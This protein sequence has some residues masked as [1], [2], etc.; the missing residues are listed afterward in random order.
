VFHPGSPRK[1]PDGYSI[2][3]NCRGVA[4]VLRHPFDRTNDR[5][6]AHHIA[7]DVLELAQGERGKVGA[8]VLGGDFLTRNFVEIR[9]H[10]GRSDGVALTAIVEI[11]KEFIPREI[12][13]R[14]D[15]ARKP[16][17]IDVSFGC[18]LFR[19]NSDGCGSPLFARVGRARS[20]GQSFRWSWHIRYCQRERG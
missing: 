1:S 18:R 7:V 5:A 4:K 10:V 14:L 3:D 20:S 19:E 12:P 6:L 11:L 15:D 16:Q 17:I 2:G 8:K 13:T 9:I